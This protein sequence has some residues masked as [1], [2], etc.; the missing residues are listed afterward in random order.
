LRTIVDAIVEH[1]SDSAAQAVVWE[2][3]DLCPDGQTEIMEQ[4]L[5][6]FGAIGGS[7]TGSDL[8]DVLLAEAHLKS[9]LG[10]WQEARTDLETVLAT[11]GVDEAQRRR[12][13]GY[14]QECRRLEDLQTAKHVAVGGGTQQ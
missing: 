11:P 9:L 2:L 6:A 7:M 5:R 13:E 14:L 8:V 10:R 3:D 1:P 4:K 12:A